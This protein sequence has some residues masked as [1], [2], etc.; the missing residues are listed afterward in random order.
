[1][2]SKNN[3]DDDARAL[4]RALTDMVRVYQFRD[5]GAICC[6]DVSPGQS[7]AIERLAIE[8]PM[9][10]NDL[11]ASL[12]LEKSSA[13]RLADGLQRKGYITRKPHPDDAR[14]VLLE[15]TRPGKALFRKIERD[16][17]DERRQVLSG[18]SQRE[19]EIVIGAVR[20]LAELASKGVQ[21][22]GGFCAR[23]EV[24]A[25]TGS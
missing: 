4:Q 20:K 19:R 17:L 1:M 13:S 14:F 18:L 10:M 25:A 5:R 16:L 8:G 9:T 12:F 3:I 15:L 24:E 6:Y 11:A 2:P 22:D 23:V 21:T 7:H